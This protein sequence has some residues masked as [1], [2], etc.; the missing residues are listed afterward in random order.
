MNAEN[1]LASKNKL[2]EKDDVNDETAKPNV[3]TYLPLNSK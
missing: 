2:I 3:K 1:T